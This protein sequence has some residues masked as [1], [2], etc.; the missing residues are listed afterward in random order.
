MKRRVAVVTGTRAEYGLLYWIIKGIRSD[1]S[2]ELNLIATGMHLSPEF[3]LT[4]KEIE[5][6]G[7]PIAERVEMLL[8]GD[9]EH[10]I[11]ASMGIGLMGFAK[12][13]ERLRPDMVVLLGDRFEVLSAAAAAVPFRIPIAHIHGGEST[14]SLIDE[15][16]RHA[17]TKLSHLHFTSTEAYRKRVVQ[18][19]EDPE[20]VI[21][22]GAPGLD[23]IRRLR[24]M[25]R[26]GLEKQLG[27]PK[28]RRIGVLTYHPVTLD[29]DPSGGLG[30]VLRA[31]SD[32]N[33]GLFWVVTLPNADTGGR[34]IS[35]GLER[36]AGLNPD[37]ARCFHSLGRVPY[38]SLLKS[39]SVMLGNSSS[40]IIE[41]P[42]FGLPVVNVG[43]RQGGRIRAGNVIDVLPE[44][45]LIIEA[46]GKALSPGFRE[47]LAGL[48]NPYGN[49]DA[50]G[51]IIRAIKEA[52]TEKLLKKRFRELPA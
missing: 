10:S 23:S 14:E 39:A 24:L 49:G 51:K 42:S 35:G 22:A 7:F 11:A 29:H 15:Q 31:V 45:G 48:Q 8:S 30:E 5:T 18:M 41:A 4:V 36:F 26:D 16:I 38:L 13:Y 21:T 6:D 25:G 34:T 28:G 12:A 33:E 2:L 32:F 9:T 50:S 52:R 27:I 20:N 1:S 40:G 3:G 19:G 37:K 17:V 46:L 43:G 44:S 47:S